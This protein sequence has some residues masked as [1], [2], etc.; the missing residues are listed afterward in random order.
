MVGE[1]SQGL[2]TAI[3]GRAVDKVHGRVEGNEVGGE[4]FGLFDAVAGQGG[5]GGDASG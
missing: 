3:E 1:W 2:E 4:L 5:V